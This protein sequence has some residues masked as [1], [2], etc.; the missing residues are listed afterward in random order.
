M[1][2]EPNKGTN[3]IVTKKRLRDLFTGNNF[4][5]CFTQVNEKS[6]IGLLAATIMITKTNKGST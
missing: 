2:N 6:K 1:I 4:E 5:I 3:D